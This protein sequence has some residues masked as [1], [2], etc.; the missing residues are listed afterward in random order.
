MPIIMG[1]N[2]P[3]YTD[4]EL[5][6]FRRQNEE[7]VTV[8]GKHYTLYEATQRQRSLERSIRKRKG[9]IL[10]DE[11]LGDAE[12][13]QQDQI[14]L[15]ILKQ[16]YHEFSKAANLPEQYERLEKA[17]FTWKHGKAAEKVARTAKSPAVV[18]EQ[19]PRP[20][21]KASYAV[22]WDTIQ[23]ESYS[24]KFEGLS[25][26]ERANQAVC[27]R[28]RWALNNRDGVKTEE[29]Y[30]IDMRTGAEIARITD[31][32]YPQGVKRTFQFDRCLKE[33]VK[34]GSD[35]MLVHNHPA[36]S[37][38]SIGD[39][40]ALLSTPGAHGVV[41]GHDGSVYRYSSPKEKI[42]QFEFDVAI[43]KYKGYTYC[44]AHE[45]ALQ[46]LTGKYDFEFT[47]L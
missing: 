32:H 21:K 14:R 26:N 16:R 18:S 15:Q 9:H 46:D 3:Q 29:I 7:G 34:N 31:Q 37:P 17:G 39:L 23:S 43:L 8:D 44:T 33:A 20:K 25:G 47:R 13:L 41:V 30:A 19:S 27:T 12:K 28:A 40:N 45:K 6:E 11:E 36:G 24:R 1:V 22:D 5:E 35:I 38:P 42:P 4:E 10:V 2:S